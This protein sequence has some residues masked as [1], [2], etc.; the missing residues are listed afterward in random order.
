MSK[1]YME[2]LLDGKKGI[3][4]EI[5]EL[6]YLYEITKEKYEHFLS[7]PKRSEFKTTDEFYVYSKGDG[8]IAQIRDFLWTHE[9]ES[10]L[11][12][13]K[14]SII[15]QSWNL[16]DVLKNGVIHI[17]DEG[18]TLNNRFI[19]IRIQI[20]IPNATLLVSIFNAEDE[21]LDNYGYRFVQDYKPMIKS[22]EQIEIDKKEFK[23]SKGE[24]KVCGKQLYFDTEW[25][26]ADCG[27]G[28]DDYGG[29]TQNIVASFICPAC[30]K[31]RVE[32]A[33]RMFG[34]VEKALLYLYV[35][36]MTN[37][38]TL[39]EAKKEL[40]KVWNDMDEQHLQMVLK[41]NGLIFEDGKL[42]HTCG[43]TLLTGVKPNVKMS[44][45][46]TFEEILSKKNLNFC[47]K[48]GKRLLPFNTNINLVPDNNR[49]GFFAG[50]SVKTWDRSER[51]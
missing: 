38:M 39:D 1:Y 10:R 41:D 44:L 28:D 15:N 46:K 22:Q 3:D 25:Y 35:Q 21:L 48:C 32:T 34:S 11:W 13:Q 37:E 27:Y 30:G 8:T 24:C 29:K 51:R 36:N 26:H 42:S 49:V 33:K 19:D 2:I 45:L 16:K 47:P 12:N 23:G 43:H 7:L 50:K 18:I 31:L 9:V 5:E 17:Y 40:D 20:K 4:K 14:L 6:N